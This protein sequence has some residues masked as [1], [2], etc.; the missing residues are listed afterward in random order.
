VLASV[1][2]VAKCG[3][4]RILPYQNQALR[5]PARRRICGGVYA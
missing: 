3:E 2:E 1:F 5:W 4:H